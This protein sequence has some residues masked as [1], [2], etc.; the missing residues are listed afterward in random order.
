MRGVG[1][2]G[3][4][5]DLNHC[6]VRGR[7]LQSHADPRL[8]TQRA[9]GLRA[10][11]KATMAQSNSFS[12]VRDFLEVSALRRPEK[13][14]LI[15]EGT[16]F[17]YAELDAMANRL[18]NFLREAGVG[19]GDRVVIFLNNTAEAVVSIFATL[20]A[21]AAFVVINRTTKTDKLYYLL[22]NC[23]AATLITDST[24]RLGPTVEL[25]GP[26]MPALKALVLCGPSTQSGHAP[27][28]RAVRYEKIQEAFSP[29][30]PPRQN[31]DLDLACLIYTSG[32][33]GEPKGVMCDHSNV[34]FVSGSIIQY[35]ENVKSD[36]VIN[37][38]PLSSTYGLYQVLLTFRFGGTL[39]L[40]RSF[41]YPAAVLERVQ[42]ERV[43]GFPA[44]PT[45]FALL[46]KMDLS[47]F[48]LSSLR[49]LTNAAAPLPTAHIL[50][51]R[52]KFP[53][54]RMFSMYGLTEAKR[55]LYMPPEELDRRPGSVGIAI[56]GTEAWLED[57]SGHRP[58]P[59]QVGEL[60]LR[61]R[62]VMRGYWQ[63]PEAT[64]KRFRP[65]PLPG[66]RLCYTGDLFR[67]DEAGFFY[68]V[69]RQDDIIKSRGEKVAPKAVENV[70]HELPEIRL[71]A[72]IG[73]PDKVL[74]QAI[75]AFVVQNGAGLTEAD[76][77]RHCR[78]QLEDFMVPRVVEFCEALPMTTSGKIKKTGLR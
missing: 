78:T 19:R 65:G 25:L 75:K 33:T 76:V 4:Q 34:V 9:L 21:S 7:S 48:D 20:K 28:S 24:A 57:E 72:V 35:L 40:E 18:A 37:V 74:G 45:L 43:T 6:A 14:A 73:V 12:L 64:T 13:V 58:S 22:G 77:I 23:R 38:L 39:V 2:P 15:C 1:R 59:G 3:L 62:H 26:A 55:G 53:Q 54:A 42:Q 56:P 60:V 67:Q 29:A 69:A 51:I 32:S 5:T 70:L 68:F 71:A 63:A 46:L 50:E 31:I 36:V 17:T 11:L 66:E 10:S 30:C 47:E 49:Y 41:T 61:G 27:D 8:F 16:R 44:V 52:R